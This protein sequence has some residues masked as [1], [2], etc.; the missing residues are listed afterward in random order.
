MSTTATSEAQ[1]GTAR[2]WRNNWKKRSSME[3]KEK[4]GELAECIVLPYIERDS[5]EIDHWYVAQLDGR[6]MK[7]LN[8][9]ADNNGDL[10]HIE[11]NTYFDVDDQKWRTRLKFIYEPTFKEN[12]QTAK[13]ILDK[14]RGSRLPK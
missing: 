10:L 6:I 13:R 3:H 5:P 11:Q 12:K 9:I 14:I 4:Y 7:G 8:Y 1:K 2:K